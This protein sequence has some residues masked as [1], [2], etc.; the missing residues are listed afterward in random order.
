MVPPQ[1]TAEMGFPKRPAI[2]NIFVFPNLQS[3]YNPAPTRPYPIIPTTAK[4]SKA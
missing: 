3:P 4:V 2:V 1:A